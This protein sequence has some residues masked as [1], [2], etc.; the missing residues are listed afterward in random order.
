L[1]EGL[2]TSARKISHASK[3]EKLGGQSPILCCCAAEKEKEK[4]KKKRCC[5]Q[6]GLQVTETRNSK[7]VS[8]EAIV[9]V[10]QLLYGVL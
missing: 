1:G 3:P 7:P 9:T 4:K 6:A 10:L 2:A 8:S 5:K